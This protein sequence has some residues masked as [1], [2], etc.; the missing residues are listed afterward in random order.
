MEEVEASYGQPKRKSTEGDFEVWHYSLKEKQV[1][2]NGEQ[3]GRRAKFQPIVLTLLVPVYGPA[4][5]N[6]KVYFR[7]RNI[8]FVQVRRKGGEKFR[9]ALPW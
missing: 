5:E 6:M 3:L 1:A 4:V 2:P 8:V 9:G 7:G